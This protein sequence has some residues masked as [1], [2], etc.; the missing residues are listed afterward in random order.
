MIHVYIYYKSFAGL[1]EGALLSFSKLF[2]F[3]VAFLAFLSC[4]LRIQ[5]DGVHLLAVPHPTWTPPT[6]GPTSCFRNASDLIPSL[7]GF[8]MRLVQT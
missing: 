2:G 7:C 3:A 6:L 5:Q 1:Y 8:P 4:V